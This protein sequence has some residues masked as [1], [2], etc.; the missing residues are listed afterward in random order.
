MIRHY[1]HVGSALTAAR[2]LLRGW[3]LAGD[4]VPNSPAIDGGWWLVIGPCPGVHQPDEP[5]PTEGNA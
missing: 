3:R 2:L 1:R 5:A 4:Y